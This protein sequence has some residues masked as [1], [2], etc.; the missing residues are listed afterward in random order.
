MST[1]Y[2]PLT[3]HYSLLCGLEPFDQQRTSG[4]SATHTC[5]PP[6]PNPNPNP[7]QATEALRHDRSLSPLSANGEAS[8]IGREVR[9][10]L[11]QLSQLSER[12]LDAEIAVRHS[13]E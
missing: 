10:R 12:E 2:S 13:R 5:E 4:G 8:P 11:Q 3:T 7:N 9:A 6:N 1:H